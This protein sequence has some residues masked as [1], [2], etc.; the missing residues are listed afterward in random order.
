MIK[1]QSVSVTD[2]VSLDHEMA[3][4]EVPQDDT[5]QVSPVPQI[6]LREEIAIELLDDNVNN[7]NVMSEKQFNGLVE[8]IQQVGFTDPVLVWKNP[9]T[10][11]RYQIVGG[12]HRKE[13]GI[14]LG[15]AKVPCT[16]ILD[17]KFDQDQAHFQ[18]MRHNN[19]KGRISAQKFVSLYEKYQAKYSVEQMTELFGFEEQAV[20]EKLIK[21]TEKSLPKGMKKQ[22]KEASAE[23]KTINDLSKV[24][25]KLFATYGNTLPHGFMVMD[26]GGKDSVWIRMH[27]SDR[28]NFDK[29]AARCVQEKKSIDGAFRV[30]LQ[31]I[32]GEQLGQFENLFKLLPT[33]GAEE[34]IDPALEEEKGMGVEE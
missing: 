11:G 33:V 34:V 10:P 17:P 20:L 3:L 31:L 16:V 19:L 26:F 6:L 30:I 23:I 8:N 1:I 12:H 4:P 13:A 18:M 27:S 29:L 25:N 24:L 21:D 2:N 28:Q 9:A 5:Q 14:V 22:F 7:A 15:M 32:A